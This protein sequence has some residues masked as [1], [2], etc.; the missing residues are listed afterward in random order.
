LPVGWLLLL[1]IGYLVVIGP[2]DQYWLKKLNKQMLTWLTFPAYVAFFSLLIYFIGYKLRAGET[3]WN[4]LHVV[5]VIPHGESADLR[6]RSYGSIYSPVNA[7][8]AFAGDQGFATFR[9]E[10]S[11][12]YG[13]GQESSRATVEQLGNGFRAQAVVPVWTSQLFVNDWWRQEPLPLNVTVTAKDV[14][15]DNRL[16]VK[17]TAARLVV[18][19][20][21]L[22]LDEIPAQGT[23]SFPRQ[24]A[25]DKTTSLKNYVGSHAGNFIAAIDARRR[26]FGD[27]LSGQ[28]HDMTNAAMAASF[29]TLINTRDNYNNL[30]TPPGFDLTPLVQ[31]GDAVFLA[32]ASGHSF[33][34]PLSQFAARRGTK[35]T[36][37]RLAVQV[38][39]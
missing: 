14:T 33:T 31:R 7:R 9:G 11:G 30:S 35:H 22:D 3:E 23:K 26:A 13:G 38:R 34:K 2:L 25:A 1:L 36:L 32:W 6:G 39:N 16:D 18:N 4:E 28:I 10:F 37:V 19:D 27:N 21:V 17:L 24:N 5:D 12:N 15:V 20:E 8:Y 29:V